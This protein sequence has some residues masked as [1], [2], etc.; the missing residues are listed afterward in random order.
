[1]RQRAPAPPAR[2]TSPA[3]RQSLTRLRIRLTRSS[4]CSTDAAG[5]EPRAGSDR[6][7]LSTRFADI[8]RTPSGTGRLSVTSASFGAGEFATATLTLDAPRPGRFVFQGDA[9]GKPLTVA[10]AGDGGVEP[11]RVE[12]RLTRLNGLLGS[13][14]IL[15]EQPLTLSKRGAD[16][17]FSGLALDLGTGRIT[18]GGLRGASLSLALNAANLPIAS[19][20]RLMGYRNVRGTLTV[21]TTL[22]GTLRAPQGHVSLNARELTLASSKNSPS[23]GLGVDGN[24]NGRNEGSNN[25]DEANVLEFPAG[26]P[27]GRHLLPGLLS[28]VT[29]GGFRPCPGSTSIW[30]GSVRAVICGVGP[31]ARGGLPI[32]FG[33][34][35]WPPIAESPYPCR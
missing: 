13:D 1:M 25:G 30:S 10:L 24:W 20:A 28:A 12:M 26:R 6:L 29:E 15:L 33:F 4:I 34:P 17:A 7:T 35:G 31:Y 3:A 16:L 8:L 11:G 23:L 18:G 2:S 14:R 21:A 32:G 9:K 27:S 22:G 5:P 19:G